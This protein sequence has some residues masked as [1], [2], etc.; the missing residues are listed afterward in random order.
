MMM[1]DPRIKVT[2]TGLTDEVIASKS[3][4]TDEKQADH[5]AEVFLDANATRIN[6]AKRTPVSQ[7]GTYRF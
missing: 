6:N 7:R 3:A 4:R 2:L 1:T 5:E